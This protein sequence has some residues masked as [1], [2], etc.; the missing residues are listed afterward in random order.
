MKRFAARL[1]VIAAVALGAPSLSADVKT[2]EKV[3]FSMEGVMGGIVRLFGG[4]AAKEGITSTVA[5]KGGRKSTLNDTTG[6]IV[7]LGEEKV[8]TLDIKKKEYRVQTFAE[9]RAQF[10]KA[11]ADAQK[12]AAQAKPEEKE[13]MEEAGRQLE[14]EAAV[15]KTGE[16]KA[17]A[18]HDTEQVI[19]TITGHEKDKTLEQSGGFVLTSDMWMAPRIAAL[20][21][22]TEFQIKYVKAVY[23]G[24]FTAGDAQQ[25]A[26]LVAVYPSFAKMAEQ[27][28][29]EGGK[30]QGT[31]LSTVVTFEGVKSEEQMKATASQSSNAG[32]TGG[33]GGM[34]ARRIGGNRNQPQARTKVMTTTRD[35]LSIATSVDAVDVAI[36]AGYKERK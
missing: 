23:G 34:L 6:E 12:Q 35:L 36:P 32:A 17:I 21:E 3:L 5:V 8:Y 26:G 16:R 33:L 2:T 22:L 28:R 31:A 9:I 25:M 18:G 7:D 24:L 13:Q 1:C 27:L 4:K 14:F 20:E 30:L 10:E 15:R 19:L 11:K 29:T